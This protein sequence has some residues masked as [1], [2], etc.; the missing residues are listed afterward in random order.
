M[1]EA[2]KAFENAKLALLQKQDEKVM[3]ER[4]KASWEREHEAAKASKGLKA[5]KERARSKAEIL[6]AQAR[7]D[8][9][10]DEIYFLNEIFVASEA[11][12]AAEKEHGSDD[13]RS[14][15]AE[16]LYRSRLD[17]LETYRKATSKSGS[18][19]RIKATENLSPAKPSKVKKVFAGLIGAVV[20]VGLAVGGHFAA[21]AIDNR[22]AQTPTEP[23]P[24]VTPEPE[25]DD[26][27]STPDSVRDE[28]LTEEQLSN[29][30]GTMKDQ[31]LI[32]SEKA[33]ISGLAGF[34]YRT[35]DGEQKTDIYIRTEA[36][37][38]I[39]YQSE[40]TKDEIADL[41]ETGST[42]ADIANAILKTVN[43]KQATYYY[44]ADES[45][46]KLNEEAALRADGKLINAGQDAIGDYAVYYSIENTQDLVNANHHGSVDLV[47]IGDNSI[48][49][50]DDFATYKTKTGSSFSINEGG[51]EAVLAAVE[52][53]LGGSASTSGFSGQVT[54][55]SR[56]AANVAS[57]ELSR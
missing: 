17:N 52:K 8:R 43:R 38:L 24:I 1:T 56:V 26:S 57:T 23:T 55:G 16:A 4:T 39:K 34:A 9:A 15:N 40:F 20:A 29:L 48:V 22:N 54:I 3:H 44:R 37:T 36:G 10:E 5:R 51:K 12:V 49:E 2:E 31:N 6:A 11:W 25:P 28:Q 32:D 46:A 42:N 7:V 50:L 19:E 53:K 21:K 30:Q 41:R 35:E 47:A 18:T 45:L 33:T 14:Q 13:L 27:I